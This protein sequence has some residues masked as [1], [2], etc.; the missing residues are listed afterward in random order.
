MPQETIDIM[1]S[2]TQ[3]IGQEYEQRGMQKGIQQGIQQGMQERN[4]EIA[5]NMLYKL[6][7][8]MKAVSEA[9]GLSR[10]ELIRLQEKGKARS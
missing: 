5:K 6:H 4:W 1:I 7:L 8:D 2:I 3:A 9:T 10:A